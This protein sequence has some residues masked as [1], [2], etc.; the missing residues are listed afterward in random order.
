MPIMPAATSSSRTATKARPWRLRRM[1]KA[2]NTITAVLKRNRWYSA[3]SLSNTSGPSRAGSRLKP[4]TP[5]SHDEGRFRTTKTNRNCAA[6][7]VSAR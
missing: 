6:M 2:P 7:V 5:P 1:P 3:R 4:L